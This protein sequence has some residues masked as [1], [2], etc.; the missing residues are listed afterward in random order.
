MTIILL[1]RA[2]F[3]FIISFWRLSCS[4]LTFS[5]HFSRGLAGE[6]PG[7]HLKTLVFPHT[8]PFGKFQGHFGSSVHVWT[9]LMFPTRTSRPTSKKRTEICTDKNKQFDVSLLTLYCET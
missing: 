7:Q 2:V 4:I 3:L 9:Q 1:W 8:A 6:V 5:G